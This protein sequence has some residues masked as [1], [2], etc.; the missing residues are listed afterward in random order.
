MVRQSNPARVG[1]AASVVLHGLMILALLWA[2]DESAPPLPPQPEQSV[3]MVFEPTPDSHPAPHSAVRAP[4]P[5][6]QMPE[7]KP[8]PPQP[9]PAKEP[10]PEPPPPS[11]PPPPEA[12][13]HPKPTP[14]VKHAARTPVKVETPAP[15]MIEAGHKK[16]PKTKA[17]VEAKLQAPE[18]KVEKNPPKPMASH[19]HQPRQAPKHQANSDS[20]LATLDEFRTKEKQTRPPKARASAPVSGGVRKGG[21]SPDSDTKALGLGEQ[22]AIGSAVRRCYSEDTAARDYASFTAHL[23]VTVDERGMARLVKFA[24]ETAARMASDPLY[25]ARAERARAA[26]LS[27]ECSHLPVPSRLLGSVRQFR[28]VFRP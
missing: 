2:V 7:P 11:P 17:P 14:E 25:R 1:V 27:P 22:K 9:E 5:A 10:K 16:A 20:L 15:S 4:H 23:V 21:G 24:P 26:V 18:H 12:T 13:S 8:Q 19:T 28:F 6:P 3:D